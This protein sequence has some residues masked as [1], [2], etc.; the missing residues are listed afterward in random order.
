MSNAIDNET[1]VALGKIALF[2]GENSEEAMEILKKAFIA[3]NPNLTEVAAKENLVNLNTVK[4]SFF[5]AHKV[6]F[7][8]RNE[9][10]VKHHLFI[11]KDSLS[12]SLNNNSGFIAR[13]LPG[14]DYYDNRRD[15]LSNSVLSPYQGTFGKW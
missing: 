6:C 14:L 13:P 5:E 4:V 3:C 10:G 7:K 2:F 9:G 12:L 11:L 15:R 1:T 8:R